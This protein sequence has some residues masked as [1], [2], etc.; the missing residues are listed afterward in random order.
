MRPNLN[1]RRTTRCRVRA[2]G[3]SPW[4]VR[5]GWIVALLRDWATPRHRPSYDH[6]AGPC[7]TASRTVRGIRD[8]LGYILEC[9]LDLILMLDARTGGPLTRYIAQQTGV[10]LGDA[11]AAR[12][13]LRCAGT[14]ETDVEIS[15]DG[16]ALLIEDKIDAAFTSG[17]P[18]SYRTE[19]DARRAGGED[20]RSVLVCPKRR[21]TQYELEA[22]GSFDCIVE[23]EELIGEAKADGDRFSQAAVM[24]LR[25]A[26][27]PRPTR[28]TTPFD[29]ARSEWADR[30][31]RVVASLLTSS[32][33]LSLGPGSLRTATADW[34]YFPA[35][36]STPR[37]CG[38][39]AIGCQAAR[40]AWI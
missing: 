33:R 14:R 7:Q 12:S 20:V 2:V 9:D 10:T 24:V 29:V 38:R 30:Y 16:G 1:G 27:E 22:G 23:I 17:Q 37:V 32:D 21:R 5:A 31:R 39:S 18:E 13:T 35:A 19:V 4:T 34:M 25:A 15:W 26:A 11:L 40:S 28:P 6:A 36:A 8:E 3:G